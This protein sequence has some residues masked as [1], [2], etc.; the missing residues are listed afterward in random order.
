MADLNEST[1]GLGLV[2]RVG[3]ATG[4]AVIALGRGPQVGEAVTGDVVNTASR[5]QS[6]A[7]GGTVAVADSTYDLTRETFDYVEIGPVT[8]KGK[9]GPS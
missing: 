8:V 9:A 6:V 7:A 1:P 3:I 2:A 4:E 5:V